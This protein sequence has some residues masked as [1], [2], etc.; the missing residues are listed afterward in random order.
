M[1]PTFLFS[2]SPP[3][4]AFKSIERNDGFGS[5]SGC[6]HYISIFA[7]QPKTYPHVCIVNTRV[8]LVQKEILRVNKYRFGTWKSKTFL[9]CYVADSFV[10]KHILCWNLLA[11]RGGGFQE[12]SNPILRDK[13]QIPEN[14]VGYIETGCSQIR[15]FFLYF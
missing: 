15:H 5:F 13:K 6:Y 1:S 9:F 10:Y 12:D 4:P 8:S 3:T 11:F 2:P 7:L 14:K